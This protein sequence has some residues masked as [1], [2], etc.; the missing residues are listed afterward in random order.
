MNYYLCEEDWMT[1]ISIFYNYNQTEGERVVE[2]QMN[3]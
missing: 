2:Q 3:R 1:L